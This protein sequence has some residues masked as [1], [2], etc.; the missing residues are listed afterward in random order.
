MDSNIIVVK[1]KAFAV[2][3]VSL[4]KHL[5]L[6]KKEHVLSQQLLK[7]GTGMG[8]NIHAAVCSQGTTDFAAKMKNALSEAIET[9]YWL[10]LLSDTKYITEKEAESLLKDC[11]E[12]IKFLSSVTKIFRPE[13]SDKSEETEST[14]QGQGARSKGQ[15]TQTTLVHKPQ[16]RSR[17][18][19]F[20]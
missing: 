14:S 16:T 9:E 1:S 15:V 4:Y 20:F 17:S 2:K 7:C 12:L 8:A 18:T 19:K 5:T 6:D 11:V 13:K 3:I 10:E